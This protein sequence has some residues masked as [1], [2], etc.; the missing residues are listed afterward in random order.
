MLVI[1][2]NW[3]LGH[4][5]MEPTLAAWEGLIMTQFKSS[6]G[7]TGNRFGQYQSI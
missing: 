3:T 6:N 1:F 5:M 7:E 4:N 2:Y